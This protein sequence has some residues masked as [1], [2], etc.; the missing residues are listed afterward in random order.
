[1]VFAIAALLFQFGSAAP[2]VPAAAA[3]AAKSATSAKPTPSVPA[4][5]LPDAPVPSAL[6]PNPV[7]SN[8]SGPELADAAQSGATVR[9]TALDSAANKTQTLSTIHIPEENSK[10]FQRTSVEEMPSRRSW[11]ALSLAQS[12]AATFDAYETRQAVENG[13]HEVDPFMRPF[14]GS[15]GIYAAIQ[16]CPLVLDYTARHMQRSENPV[17]RHTWWLPQALG[18]GVYLFSATHDMRVASQH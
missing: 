1:M 17:I 11:F 15:P 16:V 4:V 12:G 3:T 6:V 18:T 2:A 7:P 8:T 9:L 14:A 13:A 10:P 5:S